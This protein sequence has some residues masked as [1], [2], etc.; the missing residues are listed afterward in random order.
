MSLRCLFLASVA[1]L[2]APLPGQVVA[3]LRMGRGQFVAGEAV[4]ATLT[5]TNHAGRDLIF[6]DDGRVNWLDFVVKDEHG[7]PASPL[8]K[9]AFGAVKIPVGQTMAR[10]VDLSRLFRLTQLGNYSVHAVIRLPGPRR[11]E[12]FLSNRLLFTIT[13]ARPMWTQKVGLPGR[14]GQT[15]EFRLMTYSGEQKTSLYVQVNDVR[16]G[17]ALKTYSLGE[18]LMFRK[19][20]AT[21]DGQQRLHVLYLASPSVWVHACVDADGKLVASD[22]HKRGVDSDPSLV[23]LAG[24][25]VQVAGSAP[26]DP[27]AERAALKTTRKLSERP[28]FVYE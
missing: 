4:S 2:I 17:T 23:T 10:N 27:K 21:L 9:P 22:Y 7:M 12:G 28:P 19:P 14:S 18:A 25:K 15:R 26:Y 6:Q 1:A 8:A 24:G 5:I 3:S 11:D 16:T 13:N 20:T